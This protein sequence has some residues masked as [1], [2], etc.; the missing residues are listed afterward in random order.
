MTAKFYIRNAEVSSIDAQFII[1]AFDSTLPH[2]AAAGNIG[3]W[4]T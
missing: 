4:G 2:L 1:D 3:Q